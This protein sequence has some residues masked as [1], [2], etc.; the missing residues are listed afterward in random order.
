M[1]GR[2]RGNRQR[3]SFGCPEWLTYVSWDFARLLLFARS[4]DRLAGIGSSFPPPLVDRYS[5]QS[6]FNLYSIGLSCALWMSIL[7]MYIS[8][9]VCVYTLIT[10]ECASGERKPRRHRYHHL[11]YTCFISFYLRPGVIKESFR[12]VRDIIISVGKKREIERKK[13]KKRER[14][15]RQA[16]KKKK[17]RFVCMKSLLRTAFHG[18][19]KR[20]DYRAFCLWFPVTF[21]WTYFPFLA[22]SINPFRNEKILPNVVLTVTTALQIEFSGA[23]KNITS[24]WSCCWY[25]W[26]EYVNRRHWE[27][28]QNRIYI[29]KELKPSILITLHI[30]LCVCLC[31]F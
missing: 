30:Y 28:G 23:H 18:K 16:A 2:R 19:Y 11:Q 26:L 5:Q 24:G 8:M 14:R 20:E 21:R 22:N 1:W 15:L 27:I 25:C 7:C 12:F 29:V 4:V 6:I 13:S 9:S 31:G 10:V 17:Q 3:K